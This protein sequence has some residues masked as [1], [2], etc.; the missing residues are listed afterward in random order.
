MANLD[1]R[2][3]RAEARQAWPL[4]EARCGMMGLRQT[5][6]HPAGLRTSQAQQV[7]GALGCTSAAPEISN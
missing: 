4:Q 2:F 5:E 3:Q 1:K 7:G 6:Q